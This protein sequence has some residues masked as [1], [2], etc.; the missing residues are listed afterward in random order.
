MIL[1]NIGFKILVDLL[2]IFFTELGNKIFKTVTGL[3]INDE[4]IRRI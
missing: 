2:Q 3:F 4:A 1:A